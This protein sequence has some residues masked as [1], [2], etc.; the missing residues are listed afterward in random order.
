MGKFLLDVSDLSIAYDQ[1]SNVIVEDFCLQVES[2]KIVA[3]VGESG[4]GKTSVIR[5]IMGI[6][7]PTG[8]VTKGSVIFDDIPLLE[9]TNH[10]KGKDIAFVFQHSG[11]MLN[12]VYTIGQQYIE[13]IRSHEKMSKSEARELAVKTLEKVQ[14][15][16]AEELMYSYPFEL[17]GGMQQRV[18]IAMAITFNPQLILADEPTSALDVTTQIQVIDLLK[19][20]NEKYGTTIIIVTHNL[21]VASYMAD[22]CLVMLDGQIMESNTMSSIVQSPS[23]EYTKKLINSTILEDMQ[24]G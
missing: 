8:I 4:S 3:I 21:G 7:P 15:S 12:P 18:G 23:N 24:D 17:S 13:F 19:S 16:N 11:S 10:K 6:L 5:A 22:D 20:I 9:D 2:G 1:P 14:L